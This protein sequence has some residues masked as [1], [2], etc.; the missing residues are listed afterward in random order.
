MADILLEI[1]NGKVI[2]AFHELDRIGWIEE[3]LPEVVD[4]KINGDGVEQ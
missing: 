4:E 1:K 2:K 3:K